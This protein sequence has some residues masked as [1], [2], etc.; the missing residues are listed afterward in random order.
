MSSI[1]FPRTEIEGLSVSR[2]IIG[3]NWFLG[4]SHTSKAKD[5]FIVE[6]QTVDR[7]VSVVGAFVESGVDTIY[8]ARPESPQL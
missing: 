2:L 7:L 4:Y 1:A 8:G 5:R 6:H 3:T